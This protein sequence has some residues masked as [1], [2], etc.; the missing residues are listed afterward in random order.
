MT[1]YI[2]VDLTVKDADKMA[3]YS[4]NAAGTLAKYNG[5]FIAKGKSQTLHG[6]APFEN[7]A[8]IQFPDRDSAMAWYESSEYQALLGL[9]AEGMDCQFQLVG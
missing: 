2:V 3:E 1:A 4:T 5:E 7:K 9:R 8:I 6:E